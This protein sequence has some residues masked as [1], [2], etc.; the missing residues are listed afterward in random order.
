MK[1]DEPISLTENSKSE[2]YHHFAYCFIFQTLI[3]KNEIDN[4][5]HITRL[6]LIDCGLIT[7]RLIT[8]KHK[9]SKLSLLFKNSLFLVGGLKA[10]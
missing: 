6:S 2:S 4:K 1:R 5:Y 8:I 9:N 7:T 3:I 10:I